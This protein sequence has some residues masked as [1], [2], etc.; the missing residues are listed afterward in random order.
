MQSRQRHLQSAALLA[1]AKAV[2]GV[3]TCSCRISV[4]YDRHE[5][6][7]HSRCGRRGIEADG[8]RPGEARSLPWRLMQKA[9][10]SGRSPGLRALQEASRRVPGGV[11]TAGESWALSRSPVNGRWDVVLFLH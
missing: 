6:G 10:R 4:A 1:T 2:L 9:A 3:A 5:A 11:K 7:R 8:P